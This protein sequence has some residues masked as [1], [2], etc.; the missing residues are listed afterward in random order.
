MSN[1]NLAKIDYLREVA[2]K[3]TN[4]GFGEKAAIAKLLVTI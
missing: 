1:P 3:L 4:A 2:A